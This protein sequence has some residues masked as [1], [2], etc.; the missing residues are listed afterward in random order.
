MPPVTGT[1]P[2]L[3]HVAVLAGRS[4]RTCGMD[5][6]K[7]VPASVEATRE[8][9]S[10]VLNHRSFSR[11]RGPARL[12]AHLADQLATN[13]GCPAS[14][15]DLARALGLP[16][17]FDPSRNPL[18]RMHMSKL[19]RMLDCYARGDG[20]NDA[21]TLEIP[22]NNYRLVGMVTCAGAAS[23]VPAESSLALP[24]RQR[25]AGG[26]TLLMVVEFAG[27][28]AFDGV[29][30]F[31]AA[32]VAAGDADHVHAGFSRDVAFWLVADLLD[33][34]RVAAIGP[35]LQERVR[36]EPATI[37]AIAH[38]CGAEYY[39]VGDF[40]EG[41]R[42]LQLGLRLVEMATSSTMWTDW[43]DDP[44][45]LVV[46]CAGKAARRLASRIA[47]RLQECPLMSRA[48]TPTGYGGG[49]HDAVTPL[50]VQP[51]GA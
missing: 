49:L 23:G 13:G 47:D 22:R 30:E 8:Q 29:I 15:H 28:T 40:S 32:A 31:N 10:R 33:S 50:A 35:L 42:G 39:L 41:R 26:R 12:L 37:N 45:D 51:G 16:E 38:Q 7:R 24:A 17:G 5:S 6:K 4:K 11:S 20:R 34:P 36:R 18:V 27:F 9:V 14:Q 48:S 43:M 21:V 3:A 46:D 1:T 25:R 19:R 2:G 44:T